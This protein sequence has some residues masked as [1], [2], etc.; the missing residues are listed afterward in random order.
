MVP[1]CSTT[2]RAECSRVMPSKRG[3][4]NH[5]VVSSTSVS[6]ALMG[7]L[8]RCRGGRRIEVEVPRDAGAVPAEGLHV[9]GDALPRLGEVVVVEVDVEEVHVPGG[10]EG[11]RDVG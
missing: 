9:P 1:R 11:R 7:S 2:W 5:R 8:L 4:A 10:L 6:N 3:L